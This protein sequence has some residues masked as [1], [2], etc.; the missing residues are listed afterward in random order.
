M[1]Q[2]FYLF[3]FFFFFFFFFCLFIFGEGLNLLT[4]TCCVLFNFFKNKCLNSVAILKKREH[5]MMF[6]FYAFKYKLYLFDN[7]LKS[8]NCFQKLNLIKSI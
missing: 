8:P 5:L 1:L 7:L 4:I 6:L 2:L 3:F